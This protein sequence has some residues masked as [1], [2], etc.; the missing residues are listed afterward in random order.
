MVNLLN[1]FSTMFKYKNV[2]DLNEILLI[3]GKQMISSVIMGYFTARL[4]KEKGYQFLTWF[5]VGF[6]CNIAAL[7]YMA[8]TPKRINE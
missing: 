2:L 3:L 1:F 6:I 8:V 5:V 4:A 7:I